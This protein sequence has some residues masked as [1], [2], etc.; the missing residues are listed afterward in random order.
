M[1]KNND[2]NAARA[3]GNRTRVQR[4]L[5]GLAYAAAWRVQNKPLFDAIYGVEHA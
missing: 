1:P 5:A 2:T 3:A 4:R